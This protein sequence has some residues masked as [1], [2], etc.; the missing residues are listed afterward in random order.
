[1]FN[2]DISPSKIM[3]AGMDR[4]GF[5][6]QVPGF[7]S[8]TRLGSPH[9]PAQA[10]VAR[11]KVQVPQAQVPIATGSGSKKEDHFVLVHRRRL[12]GRPYLRAVTIK[13]TISLRTRASRNDRKS[14]RRA[15]KR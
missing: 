7:A 15:R 14:G 2:K 4:I 6:S 8:Q 5:L 13:K 11:A 10:Q 12:F 9:K 1:M 3:P